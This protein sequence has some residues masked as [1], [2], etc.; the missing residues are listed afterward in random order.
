VIDALG[1]GSADVAWTPPFCYVIAHDRH[2]AEAKLQV[3][4]KYES[5]VVLI[6]R[7]GRGEPGVPEDLAGRAVAVPGNLG[8]ELLRRLA[9]WLENVAPGWQ[10]VQVERDVD[11]VRM[12]VEEPRRV[13]AAASSWVFSGPADYV[14]DGRKELAR[15]RPG[16]LEETR[17]IGRLSEI[18]EQDLVE[19]RG[20]I[21]ARTDAG[22]E[23]LEDLAGRGFAFTNRTSTSGYIFARALL[24]QVGVNVGDELFVGGHPDVVQEVWMGRAAGGAVYYSPAGSTQREDGSMVGDARGRFLRRLTSQQDRDRLLQQVRILALTDPI[25]SDVFCVRSG[26]PAETW[27]TLAASLQ[28]VFRTPEGRQVLYELTGGVAVGRTS[29]A[30]FNGFRRALDEAGVSADEMLA[31]SDRK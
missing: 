31:A 26:L 2:G 27:S 28:K 22:I 8:P 30:T 21:L 13:V 4:R 16:T 9:G 12:L 1:D 3:V 15:V 20:C 6:G 23:R 18:V 7:T 14:G 10:P 25:P 11:A 5:S 19:Y 24:R 17:E 29:D